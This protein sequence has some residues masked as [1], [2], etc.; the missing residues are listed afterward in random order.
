M[1]T[2]ALRKPYHHSHRTLP[3]PFLSLPD[4]PLCRKGDKAHQKVLGGYTQRSP[5]C[6][7]A[8]RSS[9]K[10]ICSTLEHLQI[11]LVFHYQNSRA[12]NCGANKTTNAPIAK[13]MSATTTARSMSNSG[14][15]ICC[16]R[17]RRGASCMELCRGRFGRQ[18]RAARQVGL[19]K[20]THNRLC[21][22]T[23]LGSLIPTRPP[24]RSGTSPAA[25]GAQSKHGCPVSISRPHG[26]WRSSWPR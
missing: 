13:I 15:V 12:I 8:F 21:F 3:V 14:I 10:C 1:T 20:S 16:V 6:D 18:I 19:K 26:C 11:S 2:S 4:R 22:G 24:L 23:S 25:R 9:F 7:K 5:S 17:K